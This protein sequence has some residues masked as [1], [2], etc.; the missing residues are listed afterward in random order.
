M[1]KKTEIERACAQI[2]SFAGIFEQL[3][4]NIRLEILRIKKRK[5]D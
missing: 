3:L 4:T 5:V 1:M 2:P